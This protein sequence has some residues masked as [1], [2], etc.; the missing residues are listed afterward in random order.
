MLILSDVL[1]QMSD[2]PDIPLYTK[3]QVTVRFTSM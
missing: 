1:S 3:L 2:V